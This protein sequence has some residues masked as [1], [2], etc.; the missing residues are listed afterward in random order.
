MKKYLGLKKYVALLSILIFALST[1]L[2]ACSKDTKE[3]TG[4]DQT[5]GTEAAGTENTDTEAANT[6]TAEEAT[7]T[8][9]PEAFVWPEDFSL[10]EAYQDDFFLGTIYTDASRSGKDLELLK[11]HFNTITPENLMK[12]EYMQPTEGNFNYANADTM[13][14]FATENNLNLIGHTLAWHQQTGRWLGQN[15]SREVAIEQLK[16]HITNIVSHYK[17]QFYSFDVV[18]EAIND[19]VSLPE[20]GDWTK[21]LRQTQWLKSIGPDYMAMAFTFAHEA[22]PD[23]KL[24]Y[25]DYSL[26]NR[27]KADIVYAMVKDLKSQGI[28]IDGIGMQGHYGSDTAPG[29]VEY[30]IKRFAELGVEVSITELDVA[31]NGA[32][33]AGLTEEQEVAQAITY[34]KLFQ[35]FKKYSDTIARVTFWGTV[36]NKSWKA[37]SFPCLFNADYTPKQAVYAVLNPDQYLAEHQTQE[38]VTEAK[39]AQ[40]KYG[41]P[42]IDAEIDDAWSSCTD[43]AVNNQ[44]FAWEGA[45]GTAK[46]LW[47]E[48]FVYVLFQVKDGIINTQ[49]M[50]AYEQDSVE[51]FLD[52]TNGKTDYLDE[53]DGQYRVSCEGVSSF[54]TKPDKAGFVGKA[55]K[56]DDGY[57]VEMA[58]PL[59]NA[60]TEGSVMGFEAQVNDANASGMRQSVAKFNDMTDNSYQ[61]A[62]QWG[63]IELVK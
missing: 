41:T 42:V 12:P 50:N 40:A 4:T 17:G 21:C 23:L 38:V 28:P 22:D 24:Y 34:A 31:V 11:K 36:D 26:N 43:I 16:S 53:D 48:N 9:T 3:E 14:Q 20:D 6:E 19:G 46:V 58:I 61:S 27:S 55:K 35:V 47:D 30:S 18:N 44:I 52:Q 56:T 45:T 1:A 15:V 13:V 7:P 39:T 60:A 37:Q 62:K 51:I 33:P 57:L 49:S 59:L 29:S 8:P 25:N 10:Y 2:T 5:Q 54:G 32:S 63:V